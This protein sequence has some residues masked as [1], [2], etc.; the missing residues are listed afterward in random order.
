MVRVGVPETLG[1][2]WLHLF[3]GE[4]EL[5]RL[6]E[7]PEAGTEVEFLISP[8]Y[9]RQLKAIY[10][11][12][13]GVKVVQSLMAGVDWALAEVRPGGADSGP[14]VCDAQGCHNAMTSEWVL[15]AILAMLK[16]VPLYVGI[17]AD[18]EWRGRNRV[19]AAYQKLHL[20]KQVTDPPV[21]V[22]ELTGKKILIV[23]SGSIGRSIEERLAPFEVEI[24]R[25]AR[26]AREGVEPVEKLKG[27]LPDADIVVLIVPLTPETTGMIGAAELALMKQGALLVNAARGPVVV[28]E[29]LVEVL[30][31]G[32]IHAAV[33][34]T[35]PEPLTTGHP[36]WSAPNLLITPHIATSSPRFME[37][38]MKLA[39]QQVKRYVN[40]EPLLNV[41]KDGY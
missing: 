23:G 35:D 34:V 1:K 2:E 27:L 29:A 16:Y 36:L 17:Q 7:V 22:E 13:A 6:P 26:H 30:H 40:G 9:P 20:L 18:G 25:V 21:L 24:V 38:P 32:R 4:A 28:T 41:V 5:V 10:P 33:D 19:D 14:V 39:A 15:M 37:R 12:L 31:A 8:L 3:P 11:P